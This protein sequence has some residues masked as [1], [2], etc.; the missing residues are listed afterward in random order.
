MLT[1]KRLVLISIVICPFFKISAI[2]K[3]AEIRYK[4]EL[5]DSTERID[6]L[7]EL[8]EY[9]KNYHGDSCLKYANIALQESTDQ[10]YY[11]GKL[12]AHHNIGIGFYLNDLFDQSMS[13]YNTALSMA[14]ETNN[15][16]DAGQIHSNMAILHEVNE[17]FDKAFEHYDKA[18]TLLKDT[19]DNN[20]TSAILINMGVLYARTGDYSL[21]M[22]K[23]LE[24][25]NLMV[26]SPD[27]NRDQ[28]MLLN[29]NIVEIYKLQNELIK[30]E[31]LLAK[32]EGELINGYTTFAKVSFYLAKGN[33]MQLTSKNNEVI[34]AYNKAIELSQLMGNKRKE[35]VAHRQLAEHYRNQQQYSN[36]YKE[37]C[38][39]TNLKDSVFNEDKNKQLLEVEAKYKANSQKLEIETLHKEQ[40]INE[41]ALLRSRT[42]IYYLIGFT[43]LV[44]LILLLL[45]WGYRYKIQTNNILKNTNN[46]LVNSEKKLLNLNDLKNDLIR[47]LGH[48]LKNP[49]N[50]IIIFSDLLL[51]DK[52]FPEH[53]K[54][55]KYVENILQTAQSANVLIE[56]IV[57]WARLQQGEYNLVSNYFNCY[58]MAN[59]AIDPYKSQ[60]NNKNI[61]I[62]IN[63]N[64]TDIAYGDSFT[65]QVIIGNL[66]N[67]AIK[68]SNEGDDISVESERINNF[69][70]IKVRDEGVGISADIQEKIMGNKGLYTSPGTQNEKG[71]GFGIKLCQNYID[72][73][74]GE[75]G[76]HSEP[77][78]GSEFYFTFPI[79]NIDIK[80][81]Q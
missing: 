78:Q 56:N 55:R 22:T 68:Y 29:L 52:L 6:A 38:L 15:T 16:Y 34:P 54:N 73:N 53:S 1:I 32:L 81:K 39:Y 69:I 28:Y 36:A 7:L 17:Q 19:T 14:N 50:T 64:K 33:L 60:A 12:K 72:L 61:A 63:I 26:L 41:M 5:A 66:I 18:I 59:I 43:L 20:I 75:F 49:L 9:Y 31:Q 77:G 74:K 70:K 45:L 13:H 2:G 48:D 30:A 44:I 37:H 23:L 46:Q 58:E 76:L 47:I 79:D 80:A 65:Y 3:L 62:N 57:H 25:K 4:L 71:T 11:N 42:R 21:A 67:N 27:Y 40:K 35:M 24:A 10:D 8:A 51:L